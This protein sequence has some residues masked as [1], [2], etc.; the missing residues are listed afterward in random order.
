MNKQQKMQLKFTFL[1][2]LIST[3]G[4]AQNTITGE[5]YENNK[6]S[7]YIE[8]VLYDATSKPLT[9]TFTDDKGKFS[10]QAQKGNHKVEGRLLGKIL[11]SKEIMVEKNVD[12]GR[13]DIQTTQELTEVVVES[14]KKLIERKV[15]RLVFN[16]ENSIAAT[17]GDA[18]D[19][20]KV[21]PGL[22]VQND[23]VSV[24]GK[25]SVMVMVDNRMT[26]MTGEALMSYLKTINSDNIKS[27]EVIT[28]PPAKYD[29]NGNFGL[30]NIN[31][32]KLKK[33][34]NFNATIRNVSEQ[35][36]YYSNSTGGSLNFRKDKIELSSNLSYKNGAYKITENHE[37]YFPSDT[38]KNINIRKEYNNII[39]GRLGLDYKI[40]ETQNIGFI[41]NMY[42]DKPKN[43]ENDV[44]NIYDLQG[45]ITN[46]Y[47]NNKANKQKRD[48][49]NNFN[50]NYNRKLDSLGKLLTLNADYLFYN[51]FT[52]RNFNLDTFINNTFS[53]QNASNEGNQEVNIFTSAIDLELPYKK[54]KFTTGGKITFIE[55]NNDFNFYNIINNVNILDN[56]QSNVFNYKENIQA[57]YISAEKSFN[58]WEFQM[59][60]RLENVQ[61][62]GF[63]ATLNN[64]YENNY[65]KLFPTLYATYKPNENNNWSFN[66]SRR[67][68]R[69]SY[70]MANPF[71]VIKN[72]FSY[73]EG[74]PYIQ[75]SFTNSTELSYMYKNNF[76]IILS[77][78]YQ[79]DG[80]SQ[81]NI[82]DPNTNIIK[83]TYLNAFKVYNISLNL[84]YTFKKY[85]NFESN[86]ST[87]FNYD[88]TIANE[89]LNYQNLKNYNAYA[90]IS[91]TFYWNQSKTFISNLDFNYQSPT[92]I[93]I[94]KQKELYVFNFSFRYL[95]MDKNLQIGLVFN[96]IF[97][98][99]KDRFTEI[100][101]NTTIFHNNYYD[102]H[103]VRFS[104]LYRFGNK[105]VKVQQKQ[106]KNNEEK[107]RV[108]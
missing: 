59:G 45:Q 5:V 14:R 85:K 43:V 68:E 16:V 95:L 69:P 55:T 67:I 32:K 47:T 3:L 52:E 72:Q 79:Q 1:L 108:N 13:M 83:S 97:R 61:T 9:S 100:S 29:A 90:S 17:G 70:Y 60:L 10:L 24:I 39:S 20:L 71:R 54:I 50:I 22:R 103:S 92:I 2:L 18:L 57:L 65:L 26:Q 76:N 80:K 23:Q 66:F 40:N 35:R 25:G 78:Y 36:T 64:T 4:F 42:V 82:I 44:T 91:N 107:D 63:S 41:Y 31:I 46:F 51:Q 105:K 74:N 8:V 73:V 62:K 81:F 88:N 101:N 77:G 37:Y 58:K 93:N 11:F 12:L 21:T 53:S 7:T 33:D 106:P 49:F 99:Q 6:P 94:I 84:N 27:I 56:N 15:D 104:I 98:T 34:E 30:I 96:D 19:A 102:N 28:T 48:N 75:P 86:I 89:V 87:I 38:W